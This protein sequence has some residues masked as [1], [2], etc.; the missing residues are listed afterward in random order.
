MSVH[1]PPSN[2]TVNLTSGTRFFYTQIAFDTSVYDTFY[3]RLC[4]D[5]RYDPRHDERAQY[6][7]HLIYRRSPH[8][9]WSPVRKRAGAQPPP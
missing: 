9:H 1:S 7:R 2:H 6:S 8:A 4:Y 5:S 3:S